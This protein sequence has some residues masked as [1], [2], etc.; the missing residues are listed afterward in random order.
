MGTATTVPKRTS[1]TVTRA[2]AL[3]VD[4]VSEFLDNYVH[5]DLMPRW[6]NEK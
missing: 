3:T 6:E 4:E 5:T 1:V 2:K